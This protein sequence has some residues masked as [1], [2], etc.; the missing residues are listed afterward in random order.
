MTA[1]VDHK[2]GGKTVQEAFDDPMASALVLAAI[3]GDSAKVNALVK[4]GV[5]PNTQGIQGTTPLI[6]TLVF[7]GKPGV[8]ALL[9]NG[10][11]P[12]QK[13]ENGSSAMTMLARGNHPDMLLLLIQ[14]GG[15]PNATNGF[16]PALHLAVLNHREK[17]VDVLLSHGANVNALDGNHRSAAQVA[18]A[19]GEVELAYKL[20]KDKGLSVNLDGLEKTLNNLRFATDSQQFQWRKR[21]LKLIQ[22]KRRGAA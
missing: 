9:E 2:L 18:S 16:R 12:N 22:D 17:N 5:D 10:A 11:N 6:W 7:G 15:D 13:F 1:C 8:M 4:K 20:V 21:L 3:E 19:V 14:H